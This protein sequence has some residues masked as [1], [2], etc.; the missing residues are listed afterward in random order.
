MTR[1]RFLLLGAASAAAARGA[2]DPVSDR[3]DFSGRWEADMEK[4]DF[5]SL[6]MPASLVRVIDHGHLHLTIAVEAVDQQGKRFGGE[7]RFSL[8]GEESVNEVGGVQVVGFARRLGSHIFLHTRRK[9]DG[10]DFSV[11]ELWTLSNDGRTLTV[12]GGVR[13][14]FGDEDLIVVMHKARQ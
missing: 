8:D 9:V 1:K 12:E 7:L 11:D 6:P 14:G 4:S 10:S 13:S 2:D 3:P 5:A